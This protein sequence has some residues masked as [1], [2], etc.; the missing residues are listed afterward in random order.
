MAKYFFAVCQLFAIYF[1]V[2]DDK[3]LLCHQSADGK[4]AAYGKF[5]DF[6]SDSIPL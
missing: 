5:S 3:E 2:A 6:S 1:F 4:E